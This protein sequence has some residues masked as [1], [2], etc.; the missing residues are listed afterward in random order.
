MHCSTDHPLEF[1]AVT[2]GRSVADRPLVAKVSPQ[3]PDACRVLLVAG[4]HGDEPL[5]REAVAEFLR[6]FRPADA[7]GPSLQLGV[8]ECVNPDGAAAGRRCNAEGVDLNRDHQRLAAPETQALHQFARRLR[9]HLIIDV[10]TY[11]PRRK[12]LLRR[13]LEHCCEVYVDTANNPAVAASGVR[14]PSWR[15]IVNR[16]RDAGFC[17]G[18]YTMVTRRGRVRHSTPDAVDARNGLA[19]R[20][21][22]AGVLLE[23]R[24]PTRFDPPTAAERTR[25]ALT[26]AIGAVFESLDAAPPTRRQTLPNAVPVRSRYIDV[27]DSPPLEFTNVRTGAQRRV[28]LPGPYSSGLHVTGRV[29]P[30]AAYAVPRRLKT[31]LDLLARHGFEASAAP[32]DSTAVER[33]LIDLAVPSPR[34]LRPPR[35]IT[36]TTTSDRVALADYAVFRITPE[37]RRA[38]C[39]L[40]EPTSKYGLCRYPEFGLEPRTGDVY[41]I[42]RL[43]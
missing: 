43:H 23:G 29:T 3:A 42:V 34:P 15:K 27:P 26:A 17:S 10:H 5:A 24:Q 16:V 31:L 28:E 32:A 12:Q 38:L 40:L 41:P 35:R 7:S 13:G 39:V 21:G 6:T 1:A 33:I 8:V 9:P 25:R 19:L 4:Q 20:F 36:T 2:I 18:R 30:P 37:N 11:P 14:Q 22:A